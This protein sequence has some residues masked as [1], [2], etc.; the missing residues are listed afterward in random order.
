MHEAVFRS[1]SELYEN[2][3]SGGWPIAPRVPGGAQGGAGSAEGVLAVL[4]PR[5]RVLPQLDLAIS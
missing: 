5:H 3:S 1:G 4:P 2:R